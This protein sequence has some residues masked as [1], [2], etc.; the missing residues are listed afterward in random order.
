MHKLLTETVWKNI[1][2]RLVSFLF[3]TSIDQHLYIFFN[4]H[5]TYISISYLKQRNKLNKICTCV[6]LWQSKHCVGNV[7]QQSVTFIYEIENALPLDSLMLIFLICKTWVIKKIFHLQ[8]QISSNLI[9]IST[10]KLVN[11]FFIII[12]NSHYFI[13]TIFIRQYFIVT[14]FSL[15]IILLSIFS[16]GICSLSLVLND[17]SISAYNRKKLTLK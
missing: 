10:F 1:S 5:C 4:Y 14:T 8:L 2:K 9:F 7:R 16:L 12:Y 13:V 15:V 11:S 6:P 3:E 17:E